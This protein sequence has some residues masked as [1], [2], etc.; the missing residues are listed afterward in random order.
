MNDDIR[1]QALFDSFQPTPTDSDLFT[2]RLERKLALIDEIRQVQA[3]Q[4]RRYR[5][6][7][8]AAFVAGI[9][10]GGGVLTFFLSTPIDV[11]LFSFGIK[12]Y[13]FLFIEQNSR[14]I[15]VLLTSLMIT[16]CIVAMM[17]TQDLVRRMKPKN[18][19]I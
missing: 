9:V 8:V 11:P 10:F 14:L 5:M 18:K 15:S 12:F 3:A 16:F 13:P 2:E 4:I 17:N 6:A 1:L 19:Y 7:V